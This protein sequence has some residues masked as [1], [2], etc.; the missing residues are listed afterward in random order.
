LGNK[1]D[2][3]YTR[4]FFLAKNCIHV[5]TCSQNQLHISQYSG[6]TRTIS[7]RKTFHN[8]QLILTCNH[9]ALKYKL[10]MNAFASKK[11]NEHCFDFGFL[12]NQMFSEL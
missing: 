4:L 9:I 5:R 7:L 12:K 8:A 6:F 2:N 1:V 3:Y 11:T 10:F